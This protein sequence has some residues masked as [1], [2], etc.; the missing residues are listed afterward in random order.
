MSK[1][2]SLGR[3]RRS[4]GDHGAHSRARTTP[5]GDAVLDEL[6]E[7]AQKNDLDTPGNDGLRRAGARLV[8]DRNKYDSEAFHA[9]ALARRFSAVHA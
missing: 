3:A 2:S 5:S 8:S 4:R 9:R 7:G 1:S 6:A